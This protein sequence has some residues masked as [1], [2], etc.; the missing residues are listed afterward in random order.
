[1]ELRQALALI[2][3]IGPIPARAS[4]LF[5]SVSAGAKSKRLADAAV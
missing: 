4:A 5:P 3:D 2:S 1:M